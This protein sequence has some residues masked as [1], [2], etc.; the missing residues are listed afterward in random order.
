M[1]QFTEKVNSDIK[2]KCSQGKCYFTHSVSTNDVLEGIKIMKIGKR[3]G[4]SELY[5]DH[6]ING[7]DSLPV[8]LSLLFTGMLCHGTSPRDI[9]KAT[10]VPVPKNKRKSLSDSSNYRAIALSNVFS[11]L[12]DLI[13]L[14]CNREVPS[15]SDLQFGFKSDHSTTQC[16]FVLSEVIQHYK[17]NNSSVFLMMLDCS[18]AFDRVNYIKLFKLLSEKGLCPLTIRLLLFIYINQSLCVSWADT[19]SN[20]FC[21]SN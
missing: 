6:I 18:K 12:L 10:I 4:R 16:T 15:T 17:N 8:Y 3:D 13:V 21:V 14:K 9:C 20:E 19:K 11:K 1:D 5:S 2:N 7:C